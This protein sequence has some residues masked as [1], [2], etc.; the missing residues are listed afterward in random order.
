MPRGVVGGGVGGIEGGGVGGI[1][2]EAGQVLI[3]GSLSAEYRARR[4]ER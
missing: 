1:E 2:G 3:W 4:A